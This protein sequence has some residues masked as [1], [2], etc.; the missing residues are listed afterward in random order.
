MFDMIFDWICLYIQIGLLGILIVR[1]F[2]Y[3][4]NR[5]LYIILISFT[6]LVLV[7]GQAWW[8]LNQFQQGE[9]NIVHLY[10]SISL[11]G[12]RLA[13]LYAGLCVISLVITYVFMARHKFKLP[14][15][16]QLYDQVLIPTQ[17]TNSLFSYVLIASWVIIFGTML[18]LLLGGLQAAIDSP[19]TSVGGQTMLLI[20]VSLGKMPLLHKISVKQR[21]N[22]YD[23][24]IF[25]ITFF[26]TLINSRFIGVFMLV[27]VLLL[28]NYC[29]KQVSRR[30]ML[31]GILI[32]IFI[33]I[34]YGL[35]RD[36]GATNI[37]LDWHE[38]LDDLFNRF[39]QDE[40]PVNWF[41][42]TNVEGF[43]GLAGILTYEGQVGGIDHDFGL[44]NLT[45]FTQLIPN[46]IRNDQYLVAALAD[47]LDSLYPYSQ[48]SV[49][50]PGLEIAYAH[51]GLFGIILMGFLLGYLADFLHRKMLDHR[52]DRFLV[53]LL[54]VQSM[55]IVRN[56]LRI[57]LFFG[58][59]D[60]TML[61]AYRLIL[62]FGKKQDKR[63]DSKS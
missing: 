48:G 47:F 31:G 26:L 32:L 58:L 8:I 4:R 36:N 38:K 24:L 37:G 62:N 51:F 33:F 22:I 11:E 27:Q 54:S 5:N 30:W 15:P 29:H 16:S 13:N 3:S 60:L 35:Y 20:F 25:A 43:V 1:E 7:Q 39:S 55:N 10:Q 63:A 40:N 57:V 9:A 14:L 41:Y 50:A 17:Q 28:F 61:L 12:T 46:V 53:A 23:I 56:M 2:L 44:S 18:I 52:Q 49:V 21:V 59:A 45:L 42:R 6:M 19:G 34:V